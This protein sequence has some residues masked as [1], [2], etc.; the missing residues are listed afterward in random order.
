M[1]LDS[2]TKQRHQQ[3]P[4]TDPRLAIEAATSDNEEDVDTTAVTDL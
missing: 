4:A 1:S 2:L 3:P